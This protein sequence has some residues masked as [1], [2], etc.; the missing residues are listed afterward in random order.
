MQPFPSQADD[1][2]SGLANIFNGSS[3]FNDGGELEVIDGHPEGERYPAYQMHHKSF[4]LDLILELKKLTQQM[5]HHQKT[6]R[7]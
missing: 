2:D 6:R 3:P 7:I 4:L 5:Q 1:K